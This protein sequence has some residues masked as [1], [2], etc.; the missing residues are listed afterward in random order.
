M[1][2]KSG[3][4]TGQKNLELFYRAY[5]PDGKSAA[6]LLLVHGLFEHSGRYINLMNY[7]VPRGYSF[8]TFDQRG[9]GQSAGKPGYVEKFSY[10]LDDLKTFFDIVRRENPLRKVFLAGH[11]IG[12]LIA[13]EYS[14]QHQKEFDGLIIS[15][16]TFQPGTSA[17]KVEVFLG[18]ILSICAPWLGIDRLDAS[19][20]SR[21][22]NVVDA[23]VHD[24]LVYRGKITARLG[25]ELLDAMHN[26]QSHMNDIRIPILI[27]SGTE[28]YLSDPKSSKVLFDSI[29]SKDKTLKYYDG[30][31]HEIFNEPGSETVFV[32][33][34]YWL[35]THL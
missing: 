1:K 25:I 18:R 31:Y 3:T 26:F 7:F 21:D 17:S 33:M 10:Y 35:A 29:S 6:V 22:K 27:M 24:P 8:Y 2:F 16:A 9:H 23:Y 15:G 13:T 5:E 32:D 20:I 12:G 30:F 11:S 19:A 34:E 14:L 28:D 4:F